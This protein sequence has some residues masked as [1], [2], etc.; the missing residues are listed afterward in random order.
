MCSSN[1]PLEY[2][3]IRL[4]LLM[5]VIRAPPNYCYTSAIAATANHHS[6]VDGD[7]NF[8]SMHPPTLRRQEKATQYGVG[9]G[10]Q[11]RVALSRMCFPMPFL[12]GELPLGAEGYNAEGWTMLKTSNLLALAICTFLRPCLVLITS[13]KPWIEKSN[14]IR[15]GVGS[16]SIL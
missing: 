4:L 7:M 3:T 9:G 11:E 5:K 2:D 10:S 1:Y 15:A 12:V 6:L 13:S 14:A 8:L 16:I